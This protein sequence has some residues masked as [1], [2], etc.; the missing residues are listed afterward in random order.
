MKLGCHAVLFKDKIATDTQNV[1]NRLAQT[2]FQGAEMGARFFGMERQAE[3]AAA[4][5]SAGIELSA[6]HIGMPT[7]MWAENP[8]QARGIVRQAA[9]FVKGIP[10]KN[11]MMS[12]QV[13]DNLP[14]VAKNIN[15]AA[16][17]CLESGVVLNYHNHKGEFD[18]DAEMY[19]ILREQ[20]P[21]LFFGFDLGWVRKGGYDIYRALEENQGRVGYVHV[22]DCGD[23]R[24]SHEF[25][26]LGSGNEDLKK[27]MAYLSGYLPADGWAVVE[28]ETG[29]E[30]FERYDTAYRYLQTLMG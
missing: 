28:Y 20:A 25:P 4:L 19:K 3:L 29:E 1:L 2:G 30:N 8:E 16:E 23:D 5:Q 6:L 13:C 12:G 22:R 15:L 14:L 24:E 10:C 21:S 9:L 26:D 18:N 17:E 27:L 11:L 7:A